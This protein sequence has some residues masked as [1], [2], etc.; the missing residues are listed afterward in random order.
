MCSTTLTVQQQNMNK[1]VSEQYLLLGQVNKD[2]VF[3]KEN[4]G[5]LDWAMLQF[6]FFQK[7]KLGQSLGCNIFIRNGI[8]NGHVWKEGE[9][10]TIRQREG[11]RFDADWT[12]TEDSTGSS[13]SKIDLSESSQ[14][15]L[16][17]GWLGFYNPNSNSE[18]MRTP[19]KHNLGEEDL[20][21][22]PLPAVIAVDLLPITEAIRSNIWAV[23]LSVHDQVAWS[24]SRSYK[25]NLRF[26]LMLG[27]PRNPVF[28]MAM[29]QI[30]CF[31][32]FWKPNRLKVFTPSLPI[33]PVDSI[34]ACLSLSSTEHTSEL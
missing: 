4:N 20:Q 2:S 27:L 18:W 24:K 32:P 19:R 29:L 8:W 15:G 11:S 1:T 21:L 12:A 7:Q 16:K 5:F 26:K 3:S 22:N 34:I 23:C 6:G 28:L 33:A 25:Q 9:G 30:P 10:I 13:G 31:P 17:L 14:V